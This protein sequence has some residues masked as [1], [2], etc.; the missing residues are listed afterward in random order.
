MKKLFISLGL[1]LTVCLFSGCAS[2]L[3]SIISDPEEVIANSIER[4]KEYESKYNLDNIKLTS[5]QELFFNRFETELKENL[6]GITIYR[7]VKLGV[8]KTGE[9]IVKIEIEDLDNSGN[10]ISRSYLSFFGLEGFYLSEK[11]GKKI[12]Y[13]SNKSGSE[14]NAYLFLPLS[15]KGHSLLYGEKVSRTLNMR[16]IKIADKIY[17]GTEIV[18]E[19]LGTGEITRYYQS[20]DAFIIKEIRPNGEVLILKSVKSAIN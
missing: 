16:S 11:Y 19:N 20:P 8:R 1:V 14:Y 6:V 10:T 5:G 7:L 13:A 2:T 18:R 4:F 15:R 9:E 12:V 3:E 17:V